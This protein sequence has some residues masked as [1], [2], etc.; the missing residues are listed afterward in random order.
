MITIGELKKAISELP[1]EMEVLLDSHPEEGIY[2]ACEQVRT[3]NIKPEDSEG[4]KETKRIFCVLSD[5]TV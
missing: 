1:D 2:G 5:E 4:Y 3:E